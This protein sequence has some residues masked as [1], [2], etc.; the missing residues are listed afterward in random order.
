[1]SDTPQSVIVIGGREFR[2]IDWDSRTVAQD[3][4]M[5][6]LVRQTGVDKV[7]PMDGEAE[8]AYLAR[9][10]SSLIDSGKCCDLISGFLLPV[11][12]VEKP[13]APEVA[14]GIAKHI[15]SCNTQED[16]DLVI[17][18]SMQAVL[19]FFQQGLE[20]LKRS[21]ERSARSEVQPGSLH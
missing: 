16:R 12:V 5:Q 3:H 11:E 7:M 15:A 10:Q 21:L 4:Y 1:M 6:K 8:V 14:R 9:L 17:D 19:G 13:W 18:L 20:Q 2:V